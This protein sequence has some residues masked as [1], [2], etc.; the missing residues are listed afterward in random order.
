MNTTQNQTPHHGQH[1]LNTLNDPY[2]PQ[3]LNTIP[4]L[5]RSTIY[6]VTGSFAGAC[7]IPVSALLARST[8]V[9][10]LS[11]ILRT[12]PRFWTFDVTRNI[13]PSSLPAPLIGGL[14]GAAGGAVEV[15]S[16]ALVANKLLPSFHAL[17]SHSGRLFLGFGTFTG[18]SRYVSEE[19]PPRLFA[20]CW[21]LGAVAGAVGTGVGTW[22]ERRGR[23]GVR[24]LVRATGVGAAVVGTVISVQ[25]MSCAAV[26]E[27]AEGR[28]VRGR[29]RE[30]A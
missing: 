29:G 11:P 23:V 4:T 10:I 18:L 22:V 20:F 7:T 27:W 26:L 1:H 13:L 21:V 16:H 9:P 24:E 6:I 17:A 3:N 8:S 5:H 28:R 2:S 25:V 15:V 30:D 19:F 14:S 12:A